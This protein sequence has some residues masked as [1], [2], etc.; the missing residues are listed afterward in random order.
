[1]GG[2]IKE[3]RKE[4]HDKIPILGELPLVGRIFQSNGI[5]VEKRA[6][7]IFVNVELTDPAGKPYRDR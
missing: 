7:I 3:I 4:I 5:S 1:M 6:V 2:L